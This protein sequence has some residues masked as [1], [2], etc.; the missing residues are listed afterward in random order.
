V[1][2]DKGIKKRG[3]S[4]IQNTKKDHA[5]DTGHGEVIKRRSGCE[6]GK[7]RKR[8]EKKIFGVHVQLGGGGGNFA[9]CKIDI[10][11]LGGQHVGGGDS[12]GKKK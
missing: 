12:K 6:R 3:K 1:G 2:A 8:A 11:S 10:V 9:G 4:R 7:R 5:S